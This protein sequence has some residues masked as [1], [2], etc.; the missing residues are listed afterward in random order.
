M[1]RPRVSKRLNRLIRSGICPAEDASEYAKEL[2]QL[3][4]QVVSED[5]AKKQSKIFKALADQTR[6][7][8]LGLLEVREMCVCEIMVA[9][10]LTQPTASYHLGLLENAG[11][12]KDRKEGKWV[13]YSLADPELVENMHEINLI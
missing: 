7:K 9:L 8:I 11:L 4:E 1:A 3:A 10:G 6:L 5:S 13:F 12:I 2:K